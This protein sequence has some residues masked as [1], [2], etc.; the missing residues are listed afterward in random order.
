VVTRRVAILAF[1]KVGEPPAGAWPT[2]NY[3]PLV[4]FAA[5]LALLRD[6]G[7]PVIDLATFMSGLANAAVLPPRSA[8]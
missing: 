4:R 8:S 7:W 3:V 2:W 6:E 5:L 1:H